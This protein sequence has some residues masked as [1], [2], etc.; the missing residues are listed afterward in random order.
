M[1]TRFGDGYTLT[2][3][4]KEDNDENNMNYIYTDDNHSL[5]I[6]SSSCSTNNSQQSTTSLQV[7]KILN[8]NKYIFII[9]N[10]LIQNISTKCKLKERHF[11]NVYQFEIPYSENVCLGD[12]YKLIEPN[13]LKF[14]IIDYS[15]TQNTLDN[16]FINF[17]KEHTDKRKKKLLLLNKQYG[18][19]AAKE[20]ENDDDMD[21]ELIDTTLETG[22]NSTNEFKFKFPLNDNDEQFLLSSSFA[23]QQ[24]SS[25]LMTI[26]SVDSITNLVN[27]K[28]NSS[29]CSNNNVSFD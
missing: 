29:T 15:L 25:S 10:E 18:M 2:V 6:S 13:K 22:I 28:L 9:N 11:N 20:N 26:T 16:V 21:D 3:K 4:I 7:Q 8:S 1:K 5:S 12:I 19:A 27:K 23:Q 17:I 24:Q 14:N